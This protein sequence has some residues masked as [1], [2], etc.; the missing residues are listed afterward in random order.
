MGVGWGL[1]LGHGVRRAAPVVWGGD[2]IWRR[3][4]MLALGQGGGVRQGE[5]EGAATVVREKGIG[6]IFSL[7]LKIEWLQ[8]P[9]IYSPRRLVLN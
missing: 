6:K 3:G 7:L 8:S 5:R 1:G 2:M 4:A 9:F